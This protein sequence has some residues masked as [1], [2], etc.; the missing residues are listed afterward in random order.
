MTTKPPQ[1]TC[2]CHL[3]TFPH[4]EDQFCRQLR[5]DEE[6]RP[7]D[8]QDDMSAHHD[9]TD[10]LSDEDYSRYMGATK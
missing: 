7:G 3:R 9:K 5:E 8:N 1:I 10:H 2:R 4:R 6:Y